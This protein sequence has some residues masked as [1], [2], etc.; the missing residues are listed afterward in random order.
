MSETYYKEFCPMCKTKNWFVGD[1][2]TDMDCSKMDSSCVL[3]CF[4]CNH[5]FI[6]ENGYVT[7]EEICEAQDHILWQEVGENVEEFMNQSE[8]C[9]GMEKIE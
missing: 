7:V 4:K 5:K 9:L 2:P 3:E 6:A 1:D 8:T